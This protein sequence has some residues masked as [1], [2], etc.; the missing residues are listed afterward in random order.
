MG[1]GQITEELGRSGL[2]H[3]GGFVF[4]EFLPELQQ[5]Q[6]AAQCYRE[7]LDNWDVVGAVSYAITQLIRR[8]SWRS[9]PANSSLEAKLGA[10]FLHESINDLRYSWPDTLG[11][12]FMFIFY[13]WGWHEMC[14]KVRDG[15]S[16][17]RTASSKYDDGFTPM[18]EDPASLAGLAVEV[19]VRRRWR[20]GRD[21]SEPAAGL[22]PPV[23]S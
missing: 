11:E 8:V 9:K 23:H 20:D 21:D 3:W 6:R 15:E 19:G 2:R 17:D 16:R 22:P 4:E 5:G 12:I 1:G 18:V 14:F 10:Q 13:G 7:L